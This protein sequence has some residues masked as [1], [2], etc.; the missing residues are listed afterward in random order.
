MDQT[1]QFLDALF[2]AKE[3]G[4]FILIWLLDGKQSAWFTD[5]AQAAAFVQANNTRDVYVG[6]ATSLADHVPHL[7]L[8][9]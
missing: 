5:T 8:L 6:V 2:A 9:L 3:P 7:L 1:K 4:E